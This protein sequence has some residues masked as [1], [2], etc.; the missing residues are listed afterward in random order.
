MKQSSSALQMQITGKLI[1][2]V[3]RSRH[4]FS[5]HLCR[6]CEALHKNV[7]KH[8]AQ[9]KIQNKI[10]CRGMQPH[11]IHYNMQQKTS[12]K[13]SAK[14]DEGMNKRTCLMSSISL[15]AGT[16]LIEMLH[17]LVL[18]ILLLHLWQ[19]SQKHGGLSAIH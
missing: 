1:F 17:I 2:N 16:G 19:C 3:D 11:N 7:I 5:S 8:Y 9:S 6:K 14:A 13:E 12:L 15:L 4:N 18:R 10:C